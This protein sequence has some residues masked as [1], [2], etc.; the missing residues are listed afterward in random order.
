[1]CWAILSLLW[2][3]RKRYFTLILY[4][5]RTSKNELFLFGII[6]V[7][8]CWQFLISEPATFFLTANEDTFD[9]MIGAQ[10]YLSSGFSSLN[11]NPVAI[12]YGTVGFDPLKIEQIDYYDPAGGERLWKSRFFEYSGAIQYS[13]LALISIITLQGM[14]LDAF[15]INS[16]IF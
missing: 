4:N 6:A 12:G 8:S 16:M 3:L 10:A 5:L 15:F 1:M 2:L 11:F 14:G 9:G 7:A 13:A